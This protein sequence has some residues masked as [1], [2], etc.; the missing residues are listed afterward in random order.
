MNVAWG[1][2]AFVWSMPPLDIALL[3]I[4]PFVGGFLSEA[5]RV[6]PDWRAT[7]A[8]R[9]Q[10][11]PCGRALRI[12]ELLPVI[13]Y[14]AQGSRCACGARPLP[15]IHPIGD[16]L[17]VSIALLAVLVADNEHALWIAFSGWV[18]LFGALVDVRTLLLPDVVTL[19]LVG[20]GLAHAAMQGRAALE[21]SLVGASLG[22]TLLWLVNR[23]HRSIRGGD[24][25]GLGD[26]KLLAAAG[27][28][29]GVAAL[30]WILAGAATVALA[31][32]AIWVALHRSPPS[33]VAFGPALS[34]AAFVAMNM[35][36][37]A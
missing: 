12:R 37:G 16:L 29:V 15:R 6:W 33:L 14:V 19:G 5:A 26:A 30:P 35:Q 22:F 10:C 24:G 11:D 20:A 18:L 25:L 1:E 34:L 9:S 8:P 17:A 23:L 2:A 4:S 27:A 7:L 3:V 21:S 31:S 36:S 32:V 13:S 28:L